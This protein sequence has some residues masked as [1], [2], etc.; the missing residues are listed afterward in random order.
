M[1][2]E[3]VAV[4]LLPGLLVAGWHL[5]PAGMDQAQALSTGTNPK[6]FVSVQVGML[7]KVS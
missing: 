7:H 3:R 5:L 4:G 1:A 6:G 2:G